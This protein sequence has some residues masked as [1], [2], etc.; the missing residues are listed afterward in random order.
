MVDFITYDG[1]CHDLSP[2]G[3]RTDE[4]CENNMYVQINAPVKYPT[5]VLDVCILKWRKTELI[6]GILI[7]NPVHCTPRLMV[8]QS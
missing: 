6:K 4:G 5:D 1:T 7:C 2:I 3:E 8:I